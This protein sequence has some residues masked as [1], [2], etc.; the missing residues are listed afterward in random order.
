MAY[1]ELT[2]P[3]FTTFVSSQADIERCA[4]APQVRE[5]L[6]EPASLAR[7]GRLSPTKALELAG[8]ARA[9]KLRTVLVW[10]ILMTDDEFTACASLIEEIGPHNFDGI[11][12]QCFGAA[13][14]LKERFP[15]TP[16][17]LIAETAHCN[18]LTLQHWCSILE[19]HLERI[20][21]SIQLPADKLAEFVRALPVDCEILGLGKIL[22]FY[23]RRNLLLKDFS[24][25][26]DEWREVIAETE[27]SGS[28][29]FPVIDNTH[30]TFMYLD[31]DQYILHKLDALGDRCPTYIRLDLR[32]TNEYPESAHDIVRITELALTNPEELRRSWRRPTIAPFFKSNLTTKQFKLLNSELRYS[33]DDGCVAEI[34]ATERESHCVLRAIQPFTLPALFNAIDPNGTVVPCEFTT[35]RYLDGRETTSVDEDQVVIAPWLK[36]I[37][38]GSLLVRREG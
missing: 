18:L 10:D 33:R 9:N 29:P 32:H 31:K 6:L 15:K 17:Q 27:E 16:I 34:V 36:R 4:Q 11:R 7:E 20:I 22:L 38:T 13:R 30:G 8:L 12:V 35:L 25:L 1:N 3:H 19:G 24:E 5:V 23:S 37:S 2:P 21:L 28:R 14:Y 26:G